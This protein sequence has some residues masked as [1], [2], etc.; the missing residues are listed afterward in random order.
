MKGMVGAVVRIPLKEPAN[1][2]V[3]RMP[4]KSVNTSLNELHAQMG[5]SAKDLKLLQK[6]SKD[7]SR[8]PSEAADNAYV[9]AFF[10]MVEKSAASLGIA[11]TDVQKEE[12]A[13]DAAEHCKGDLGWANRYAREDRKS[14]VH[15]VVG[16]LIGTL[17]GWGLTF[18]EP[19]AGS[20]V[21]GAVIASYGLAG[22]FLGSLEIII[23][24]GR[25][26]MNSALVRTA[27]AIKA[28][29]KDAA[30]KKE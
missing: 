29:V 26:C 15:G 18:L 7:M 12:A 13:H 20:V 9:A 24:I 16:A 14:I 6:L 4:V 2:W 8:K 17:A 23:G 25:E 22:G 5:I 1:S 3:G 27:Y 28:A 10:E 19:T 21:R 11:L 30:Q